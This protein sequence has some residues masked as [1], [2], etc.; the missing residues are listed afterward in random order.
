M[1]KTLA[2]HCNTSSSPKW[3]SVVCSCVI[4]AVSI[5]GPYASQ[6]TPAEGA[7]AKLF[8]GKMKSLVKCVNID[9]ESSRIE[10]FTGGARPRWKGVQVN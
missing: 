10:E 3:R 5:K 9:H 6:G 1:S 7:I 4:L 2:G 8:V